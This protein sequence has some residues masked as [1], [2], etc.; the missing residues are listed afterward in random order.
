MVHSSIETSFLYSKSQCSN[1]VFGGVN[2]RN[3]LVGYG[4]VVI[5]GDGVHTIITIT[6]VLGVEFVKTAFVESGGLVGSKKSTSLGCTERSPITTS[7][8][9]DPSFLTQGAWK[10]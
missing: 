10:E 3:D 1:P 9:Y 4:D 5:Q 2:Q 6:G 8:A 7:W